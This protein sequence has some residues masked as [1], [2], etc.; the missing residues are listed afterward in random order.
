M[1]FFDRLFKRNDPPGDDGVRG[2]R[3]DNSIIAWAFDNAK[4]RDEDGYYPIICPYC[5]ET[6]HIWEA[7]FRSP[8]PRVIFRDERMSF[9]G[10]SASVPNPNTFSLGSGWGDDA[11]APSFPGAGPEMTAPVTPIPDTPIITQG[12]PEESSGFKAEIDTLY[13]QFERRVGGHGGIAHGKILRIFDENGEPTGEVESITLMDPRAGGILE[14]HE[15]IKIRGRR[16]QDFERRPILSVINKYGEMCDERVCPHCHHRVSSYI[17]IRPSF[18]VALV[19]DTKAGKTVYLHKLGAELS[20]GILGRT[21]VGFEANPD[22]R[23]WISRAMEMDR[24]AHNDEAMVGLTA[25]Q[26]MPPNIIDF[27]ATNFEGRLNDGFILNLFDFPGEA[28]SSDAR[29][30]Q[31]FDKHYKP[32][33]ERIDGWIFLFD[34]ANFDTVGDVLNSDEELRRYLINTANSLPQLVLLRNFQSR[35]L[36]IY[37][38]A[39]DKPVAFIISKSDLIKTAR[40]LDDSYFPDLGYDAIFLSN[41]DGRNY[42]HKG[43]TDL[44]DMFMCDKQIETFFE[45]SREDS[46]VF[47]SC[48]EAVKNR[49]ACWFAVSSKGTPGSAKADP[50]RVTE[51]MEWL[52]WRLGL[53]KGE[54]EDI[55]GGGNPHRA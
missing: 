52:L 22:Y 4:K 27:S 10:S 35:Y 44:C 39:F 49:Q 19:G 25:M 14:G 18:I 29:E 33:I 2:R 32:L 20:K 41:N 30:T 9:E 28:L 47:E 8:A 7:Q 38:N 54:G 21:Q 40:D 50:I 46:A 31:E 24:K 45:G 1:G 15:S 36:G 42:I 16:A 11:P 43:N 12:M 34:A 23:D 37:G 48:I 5:L 26:F 13:D 17:G 6:F 51:P 53:I 3:Y 55:P